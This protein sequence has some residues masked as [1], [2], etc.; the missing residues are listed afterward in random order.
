MI[1]GLL[2]ASYGGAFG[3]AGEDVIVACGS[4]YTAP[5]KALLT[6]SLVYADWCGPCK[7][8]APIFEQLSE[9]LS[10]PNQITFIKIN[11]DEQQ[12]VAQ[13]YGVSA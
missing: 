12:E 5:S 10:R 9:K 1:N 7:Q 4:A 13:E 3:A 11:T 8:I 2:P 6:D